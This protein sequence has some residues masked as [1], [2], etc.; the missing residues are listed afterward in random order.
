MA[1]YMD[2]QS[3]RPFGI[4]PGHIGDLDETQAQEPESKMHKEGNAAK[5]LLDQMRH[6]ASVQDQRMAERMAERDAV[7]AAALAD[8]DAAVVTKLECLMMETVLR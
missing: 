6:D 7:A 5:D 2:T 8:R 3:S 1:F 4:L